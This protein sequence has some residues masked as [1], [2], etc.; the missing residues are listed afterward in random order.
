MKKISAKGTPLNDW[1]RA[2]VLDPSLRPCRNSVLGF[3]YMRKFG[4]SEWY[5]PDHLT[6]DQTTYQVNRKVVEDFL[7][8]IVLEDD[9]GHKDR[10][11]YQRHLYSD[12][13][14]LRE[15]VQN[16]ITL[17]RVR[18]PIN[19]QHQLGLLLQLAIALEDEHD[20]PCSVYFMSNGRARE[21]GVTDEG[22]IATNL[23]QGAAPTH[24]KALQGT[25][26]PGDFKIRA[27]DAV[28]IQI[29]SLSLT[30]NGHPTIED[31]PVIAV[32]LPPRHRKPWL[33]QGQP[34]QAND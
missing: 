1:K 9:P 26:Y 17:Y 14:S 34:P 13:I 10:S 16:L 4:T 12:A 11:E 19:S 7:S 2:F 18:D 22:K 30:R 8:A 21:R 15:A 24:P 6:S 33:V 3:D 32:W 5:Y 29:H 25:V 27:A 31:V 28:T 23:F 20:E